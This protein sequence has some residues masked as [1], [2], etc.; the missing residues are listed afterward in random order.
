MHIYIYISVYLHTFI[1][2]PRHTHTEHNVT[3]THNNPQS[4]MTWHG[5][6]LDILW[7]LN[8]WH[9]AGLQWNL[10]QQVLHSVS[11]TWVT[12]KIYKLGLWGY[13]AFSRISICPVWRSAPK[14]LF[15][16]CPCS[17]FGLHFPRG[18]VILVFPYFPLRSSFS[19]SCESDKNNSSL[20]LRVWYKKNMRMKERER[21]LGRYFYI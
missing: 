15:S 2:V 20:F 6:A 19:L 10:L 16:V 13:K 11:N 7:N 21:L 5:T 1:N 8:S 17:V 3:E 14:P 12:F 18:E 9:V 4:R